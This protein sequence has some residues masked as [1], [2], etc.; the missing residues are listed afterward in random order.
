MSAVC[1]VGRFSSKGRSARALRRV[2][3]AI[4]VSAKAVSRAIAVTEDQNA[5]RFMMSP[6]GFARGNA[7][8]EPV[9]D[10]H[11]GCRLMSS[12]SAR[13]LRTQAVAGPP[14]VGERLRPAFDHPKRTPRLRPAYRR[15][16]DNPVATTGHA[17]GLWR[18]V[19][20]RQA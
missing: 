18:R 8:K 2:W 12:G 1:C 20:E 11:A 15:W 9:N 4:A 3:S 7:E 16:L 17:C 14:R 19:G 10:P 13:D 6:P 5:L